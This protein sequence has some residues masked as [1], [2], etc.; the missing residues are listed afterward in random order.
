MSK[1]KAP[2]K[3]Y[4][5]IGKILLIILVIVLICAFLSPIIL[6]CVRTWIIENRFASDTTEKDFLTLYITLLGAGGIF[7]TIWFNSKRIKNQEKQLEKQQDQIDIQLSNN[8]EVQYS[9]AI[10]ILGSKSETARIGS[11]HALKKIADKNK[12]FI[13]PVMDVLCSHVRVSSQDETKGERPTAEVQT[14]INVMFKSDGIYYKNYKNLDEPDLKNS[15]LNNADFNN[16]ICIKTNFSNCYLRKAEFNKSDLIGAIFKNTKL[17]EAVFR[18]SNLLYAEFINSKCNLTQFLYST[19]DLSK[20]IDTECIGAHFNNS[21]LNCSI[22]NNSMLDG[23]YLYKVELIDNIFIGTTLN[24]ATT[25]KIFK[26]KFIESLIG[27][28]EEID[29]SI[30]YNVLYED[31]T[32][33]R[34]DEIYKE[35]GKYHYYYIRY[36]LY[37]ANQQPDD[38]YNLFYY[39]LKPVDP[40]NELPNGLT[41][42]ILQE[43]IHIKNILKRDWT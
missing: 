22:F 14:C 40:R 9:T 19:I 10:N 27:K 5:K 37:N 31:R 28:A 15:I 2:N 20:F 18:D 29:F 32:R 7:G 24:G 35:D 8:Y 21:S 11:I 42:G 3:R 36:S 4:S 12:E 23:S 30:F 39:K 43:T 6:I 1:K 34:I 26:G 33:N 25:N 41:G 16:T 13:Q 17:E 38:L